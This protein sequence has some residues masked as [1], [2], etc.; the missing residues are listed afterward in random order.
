MKN[1]CNFFV[2]VFL[3]MRIGNG[4]KKKDLQSEI[5]NPKSKI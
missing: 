3:E 4:K 5:T 1:Q 2:R